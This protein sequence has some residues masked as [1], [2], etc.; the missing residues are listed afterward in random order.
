MSTMCCCL[1]PISPNESRTTAF[2]DYRF[3]TINVCQ[4]GVDRPPP[5]QG[6]TQFDN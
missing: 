4:T 5:T 3:S 6:A 2:L 1:D